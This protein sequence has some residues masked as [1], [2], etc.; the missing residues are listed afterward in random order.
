MCSLYAVHTVTYLAKN[1]PDGMRQH[2][3]LW[4]PPLWRLTLAEPQGSDY[5]VRAK[6]H[7]RVI[8]ASLQS[9]V[10]SAAAAAD[11]AAAAA[12]TTLL[13]TA[14]SRLTRSSAG[15]TRSAKARPRVIIIRPATRT[16]APVALLLGASLRATLTGDEM[17]NMQQSTP[18]TMLGTNSS[19][20]WHTKD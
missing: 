14:S 3:E 6:V 18:L 5:W 19:A 7:H 8:L 15:R 4:G 2:A 9:N 13:W 10:V 20:K 12:E 1:I 16:A 11:N 17:L